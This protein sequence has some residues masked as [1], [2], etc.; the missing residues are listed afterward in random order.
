VLGVVRWIASLIVRFEQV[1]GKGV[2][3]RVA[4]DALLEAAQFSCFVD[5]LLN[6]AGAEGIPAGDDL[7]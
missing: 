4:G 5:G 6:G 2:T 3:Q 1:G 7:T